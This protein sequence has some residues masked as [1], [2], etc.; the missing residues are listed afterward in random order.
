MPSGIRITLLVLEVCCQFKDDP[1]KRIWA[2][3]TAKKLDVSL[4]TARDLLVRMESAG[5][6]KS[7]WERLEHVGWR[8]RRKLYRITEDGKKRAS[9]SMARLG[10]D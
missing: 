3:D 10:V 8:P 1:K 5:W 2:Y 9:E 6:L 7:E 4:A